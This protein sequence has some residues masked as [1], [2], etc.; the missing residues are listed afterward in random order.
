MRADLR[1]RPYNLDDPDEVKRLLRECEGYLHTCRRDHHGTDFEGR[2]FAMDGLRALAARA[3]VLQ[4][5][6]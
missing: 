4:E 5:H 1:P 6:S 2:Q 3:V